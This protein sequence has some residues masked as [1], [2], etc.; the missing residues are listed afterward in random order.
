MSTINQQFFKL[1]NGK[2]LI[3]RTALA[4]D[5]AQIVKLM[6]DIVKEG[7]FTLAEPDEYKST[8]KS[9]AKKINRFKEAPDK[10]YL[11]AEVKNEIAG[12]ISFDNWDTIKTVLL[13]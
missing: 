5:A 8:I 4:K 12:F 6:K 3:L 13:I 10:I 1:K 11:V 7:P 9:E 2:K